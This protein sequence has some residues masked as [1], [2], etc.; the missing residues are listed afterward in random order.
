MKV[1]SMAIKNVKRNSSF[2]SLYFF[3]VALVLS[4]F[5]CFVSFSMNE[6]ILEKISS[7]GRVETMCRAVA[8]L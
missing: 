2:Y 3:S 6:V 5:F 1:S 7:D 4:V 8:V